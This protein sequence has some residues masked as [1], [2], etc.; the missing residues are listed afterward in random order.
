MPLTEMVLFLHVRLRPENVNDQK[1]K[2]SEE[3]LH[4]HLPDCSLE[5]FLQ[6]E[7]KNVKS[8]SVIIP[9]NIRRLFYQVEGSA[10]SAV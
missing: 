1:V 5:S 8:N 3:I 6:L 7:G 4:Q 9:E 10:G 2:I